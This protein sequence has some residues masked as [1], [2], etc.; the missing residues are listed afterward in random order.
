MNEPRA[1]RYRPDRETRL[2]RD[3]EVVVGGRPARV[4]R[5]APAGAAVLREAIGGG[6]SGSGP[7][8]E[9]LLRRLCDAGMIHPLPEPD[10]R[11]GD[12][13]TVVIPARDE[14][15]GIGRLV[16]SLVPRS[17]GVIVVDDGSREATARLAAEAGATVIRHRTSRGPAAAR[18]TALREVSTELVAFLD[19]DCLAPSEDWL[20]RLAPH[21]DPP[22]QV[23]AAPRIIGAG[24]RASDG[25]LAAAIAGY[26]RRACPLDMG[27]DASPAGIG[28]RVSFLPS[29]AMLA[30]R[31]ALLEIGGFDESLRYGE[32]VDLI[33]RLNASG[34][35][36]RYEPSV[37]IEHRSRTGLRAFARQRFEYGRSAVA[38]DRRHPGAVSPVQG[39]RSATAAALALPVAGPL[40][41]AGVA[42][43]GARR[44]KGSGVPLA[45]GEALRV[46]VESGLVSARGLSRVLSREWLPLT[47]LAAG[48]KRLRRV[49]LLG[50][51]GLVADEAR[52]GTGRLPRSIVFGLLDRLSYS[53]GLWTAAVSERRAGALTPGRRPGPARSPGSR[54]SARS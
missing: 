15:A 50:L 33:W 4:I 41:M 14:A 47:M 51:V 34:G 30:R 27:S 6:A 2:L 11:A 9:R 36:C 44:M 38:L 45:S 46:T 52:H 1:R 39:G 43:W 49:A 42:L 22:G 8:A 16:A 35:M 3:G 29:A 12:R 21:L 17:A 32:D 10:D 7:A 37:V 23:L 53:A 26:E 31:D 5:L 54:S 24:P 13:T 48:S 40:P 25:I 18:N 28:H 20:D 19:A